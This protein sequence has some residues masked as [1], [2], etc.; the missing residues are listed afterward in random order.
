MSTLSRASKSA[1]FGLSGTP[2]HQRGA[3]SSFLFFEIDVTCVRRVYRLVLCESVFTLMAIRL[4]I[5][6]M[7]QFCKVAV[8]LSTNIGLM[9]ESLQ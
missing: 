5:R 1:L 8:K 6:K 9:A 7:S 2:F 4:R 3:T